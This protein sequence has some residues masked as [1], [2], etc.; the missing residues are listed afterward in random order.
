MAAPGTGAPK[1]KRKRIPI[2]HYD[3][4]QLMLISMV[5]YSE[6]EKQLA[7]SFNKPRSYVRDVIKQVHEDWA[8]GAALTVETRR[9]QI[10]QGMEGLYMKAI[11]KGDLQTA[12]RVITEL[13]RLDGCYVPD[14]VQVQHQGQVGVGISLGAL[15]FKSPQEV[16]AR[17]DWL[18]SQ[19]A[20]RGPQVIAANQP[21]LVAQAHL[22]GQTPDNHSTS[23]ATLPDQTTIIDVPEDSGGEGTS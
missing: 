17:V 8:E 12:A 10:R 11:Q 20:A 1:K 14:R 9:H 4:V 18:K 3:R 16:A 19:I 5:P 23:G 2:E 15:G 6:I 13:G 22:T 21:Q 7:L